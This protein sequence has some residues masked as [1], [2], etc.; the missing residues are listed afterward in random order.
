MLHLGNATSSINFD[1]SGLYIAKI[2]TED[3]SEIAFL[4]LPCCYTIG[5]GKP[6]AKIEHAH[7]IVETVKKNEGDKRAVPKFN[8]DASKVTAK[9]LGLNKAFINKT[10]Q[11]SVDTA[12]AGECRFSGTLLHTVWAV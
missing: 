11:F 12:E 5:S 3:I 6:S 9:G 4:S 2:E 10:A 7:C 1:G 8:S